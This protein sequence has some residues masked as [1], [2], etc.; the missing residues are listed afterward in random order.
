MARTIKSTY[1]YHGIIEL[2]TQNYY[3]FN[4]GTESKK[5]TRTA[6]HVRDCEKVG[7][8]YTILEEKSDRLFGNKVISSSYDSV[9]VKKVVE[10][11]N[12]HF[13][14]NN[15]RAMLL[16]DWLKQLTNLVW[17]Q[18]AFN[19]IQQS[20]LSLTECC[21]IPK[22]IT[23][24]Q[25]TKAIKVVE[26]TWYYKASALRISAIPFKAKSK[27]QQATA[28]KPIPVGL[29]N[30][31]VQ[32]LLN[33]ADCSL[34][35]EIRIQG[36]QLAHGIFVWGKTMF[37]NLEKVRVIVTANDL[38]Q[39]KQL[40][41]YLIKSHI[42]ECVYCESDLEMEKEYMECKPDLDIINPPYDGSLHLR[43]LENV[44]NNKKPG[45]TV[46]SI[47]PVR[48]LEDPLAEYKQGSDYKKY[49]N[50]IVNKISSLSL[51]P[52]NTACDLFEIAN[53]TDLGIYVFN[54]EH[55]ELAF[56]SQHAL[57]KKLIDK[58]IPMQKLADHLETNTVDGIRVEVKEIT[59]GTGGHNLGNYNSS[60][61]ADVRITW[62][63]YTDGF[64]TNNYF[65]T[66]TR[67]KNQHTKPTFRSSIKFDDMTTALNFYNSCNTN[68]YRNLIQLL[69]WD[70][71]VPLKYLPWMENYSFAW[72]DADYCKFFNLTE[73]EAEFMSRVVDDYRV[74]DFIKYIDID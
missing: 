57:T 66:D 22:D 12:K 32:L 69:K 13:L 53:G 1:T 49:A 48:W 31:I 17:D 50:S 45:A 29:H 54:D 58:I 25:L 16:T 65:F 35:K 52:A 33:N 5:G 37:K 21:V 72:T 70:V 43:I 23:V 71:N 38:E 19:A 2:P 6:N 24:T 74:K 47:Q 26:N 20:R 14:K 15:S 60:K 8:R 28:A 56:N 9:F 39:N 59:T 34:I 63:P 41:K 11:V 10:Y 7:L 4:H 30:V 67:N 18:A 42:I 64:D 36:L 46:I 68:F 40:H 62:G 73:E 51:I 44:L 61:L 27:A 3:I 55:N